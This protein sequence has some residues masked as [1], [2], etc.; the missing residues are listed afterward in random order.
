MG[1][2]TDHACLI[3]AFRAVPRMTTVTFSLTRGTGGGQDCRRSRRVSGLYGGA[4][5]SVLPAYEHFAQDQQAYQGD[6]SQ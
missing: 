6:H 2:V 1:I 3:G 4:F 5:R